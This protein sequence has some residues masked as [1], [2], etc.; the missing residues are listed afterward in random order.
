MARLALI[1]AEAEREDQPPRLPMNLVR[2]LL[3]LLAL[4]LVPLLLAGPCGLLT[5]NGGY[6]GEETEVERG[7]AP[8]T[9][10][11]GQ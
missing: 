1:R 7:E 11:P 4:V 5:G 8:V 10:R 3:V 9:P 6:S 2:M